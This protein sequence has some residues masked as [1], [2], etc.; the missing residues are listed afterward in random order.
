MKR[1]PMHTSGA[2]C[3]ASLL[4]AVLANGCSA[5]QTSANP[6]GG[7]A[8][9]VQKAASLVQP[10]ASSATT[11]AESPLPPPQG[12]V[13]DYAKVIDAETKQRLEERL[14][15]LKERSGVEIGV[16]VVGT[17]GAQDIFDYSLAVARGWGIGPPPGQEGGGVLILL[18]V[19]DRKWRIQVSRALEADLPNDVVGEIGERMKPSLRQGQYGEAVVKCV[20]GLV[21]RL[22]ARR[23]R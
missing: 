4:I 19:E 13:N 21:E 16:A 7:E 12:Y 18:A 2:L 20:E 17:M 23:G 3:L 6:G 15:R 14:S 9:P 5:R 11:K 22:D 10:G 1:K 8:A